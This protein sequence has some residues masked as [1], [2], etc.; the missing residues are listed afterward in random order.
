MNRSIK[1]ISRQ[2]PKYSDNI[3]I[4]PQ[5]GNKRPLNS[6]ENLQCPTEFYSPSFPKREDPDFGEQ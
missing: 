5:I 2:S 6:S 4:T 3:L 1:A